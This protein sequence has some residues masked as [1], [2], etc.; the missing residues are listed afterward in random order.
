MIVGV[1]V[2]LAVNIIFLSVASLHQLQ[3]GIPI[4]H[5]YHFRIGRSAHH[6]DGGAD[7]GFEI[8]RIGNVQPVE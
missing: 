6:L 7:V 2:L 5:G 4:Q 8:D 3:L 1:V